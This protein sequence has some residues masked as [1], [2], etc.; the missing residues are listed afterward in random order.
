MKDNI[1]TRTAK[2]ICQKIQR[3][4][5][6]KTLILAEKP[7]MG[8]DI[9]EALGVT[10]RNE[11]GNFEN[12]NIIIASLVGHVVEPEYAKI[13]SNPKDPGLDLDRLKLAPRK[14]RKGVIE[15]IKSEIF[16]EDVREIVSCGDT[17][18]E[19]SFLVHRLLEYFNLVED[20]EKHKPIDKAKTYTRMWIVGDDKNAVI[21]AFENRYPQENDMPMVNAAKL[22]A[23]NSLKNIL[24]VHISKSETEEK[25][26]HA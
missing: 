26:E 17:D 22:K 16:R 18:A 4:T 19:G 8:R 20:D 7:S 11:N 15:K 14:D 13:F 2:L 24:D 6:G 9:A 21:A 1:L 23:K 12:K 3:N 10:E 25:P 5:P